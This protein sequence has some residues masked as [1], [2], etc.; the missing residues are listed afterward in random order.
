[1]SISLFYSRAD[2]FEH[3]PSSGTHISDKKK[4]S[5]ALTNVMQT[6]N[7][8]CVAKKMEKKRNDKYS[9]CSLPMK[10][11]EFSSKTKH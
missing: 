5:V 11:L 4:H 7:A 9:E 3:K 2:V 1:M 8:A 6:E 10:E